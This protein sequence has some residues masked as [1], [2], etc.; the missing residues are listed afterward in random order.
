MKIITHDETVT[1][2]SEDDKAGWLM[3]DGGFQVMDDGSSVII[4]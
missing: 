1:E 2:L 4:F 3:C